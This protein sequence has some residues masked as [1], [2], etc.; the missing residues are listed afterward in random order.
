MSFLS[1]VLVSAIVDFRAKFSAVD[2]SISAENQHGRKTCFFSL[3]SL[4]FGTPQKRKASFLPR[5]SGRDLKL[6][7]SYNVSQAKL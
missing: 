6:V 4:F 7:S 5:A 3:R 2:N 1:L